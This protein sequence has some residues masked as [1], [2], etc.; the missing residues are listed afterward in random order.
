MSHNYNQVIKNCLHQLK[1]PLVF[2]K[3]ARA[4]LCARKLHLIS[5]MKFHFYDIK[6][7]WRIKNETLWWKKGIYFTF[8]STLD[9]WL[10]GAHNIVL[11][12]DGT[13]PSA[14]LD[15]FDMHLGSHRVRYKSYVS[16]RGKRNKQFIFYIMRFVL[17]QLCASNIGNNFPSNTYYLSSNF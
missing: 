3:F 13:R 9:F 12:C 17:A 14:V 5:I 16:V 6:K 11:K 8:R 4:H 10:I 2:I 15:R 1:H 7:V